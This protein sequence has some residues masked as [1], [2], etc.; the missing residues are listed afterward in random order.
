[1][2]LQALEEGKALWKTN[3]FIFPFKLSDGALFAVGAIST[4][5]W[6]IYTINYLRLFLQR[7]PSIFERLNLVYRLKQR[8]DELQSALKEREV[9]LREVHHRVKNNLQIISSLIS[10]DS[11][12][13]RIQDRIYSMA[14]VHDQL[15]HLQR[16]SEVDLVQYLGSLCSDLAN[17]FQLGDRLNIESASNSIFIP[18]DRAIPLGLVVNEL[19]VNAAKYAIKTSPDGKIHVK[20]ISETPLV[21]RVEDDGPGFQEKS[22]GTGLKLV[23]MLLEQLKGELRTFFQNG[24]KMEVYV[25]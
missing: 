4:I 9:L 8:Q 17:A 10:M 12:I 11:S 20:I 2:I 15:Y 21:I 23:R 1:M 18:Y 13:E 16:F 22:D 5:E 7:I 25:P 6:D 24:Q 14:L 3:H 19:V